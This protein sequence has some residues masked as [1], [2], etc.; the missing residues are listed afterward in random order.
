MAFQLQVAKRT[1]Y[2]PISLGTLVR[3]LAFSAALAVMLGFAATQN[4]QA[5]GVVGDGTPASC[6]D[7]AYANAMMGGG[8]VTFNCGPDP[9][10][11]PVSTKVILAGEVTT[12]DGNGR[13][14]LDGQ[15]LVQLFIVS[16]GGELNLR[17]LTLT[18]GAT[19]R[20]SV[21]NNAT[22]GTVFIYKSTIERNGK[23]A[24]GVVGP[25]RGGALY[26]QGIM[27]IEQSDVSYNFASDYGGAIWNQGTLTIR[28]AFI[29][30]NEVPGSNGDGGAIYNIGDMR[31]EDSTLGWNRTDDAGGAVATIDGEVEIT[32]STIRE[33]YADRGGG[34]YADNPGTV[35]IVNATIE[36]NN[37][38]TAGNVYNN[39]GM[40]TISIHN[41][42]IANGST[43]ADNGTPSL[44][45][46]GPGFTSLGYNIIGD[47]SCLNPGLS[48]DQR[49]TSPLL[50]SINDNGGFA[51]TVMPMPGSPAINQGDPTFCPARD[52]R[53][54][55]RPQAV[56]CDVGAVEV[57][58]I[59]GGDGTPA[60]LLPLV[61]GG[62]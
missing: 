58:L 3:I 34:L 30:N 10:V 59:E 33:N 14:T 60:V 31:I 2:R 54:F 24:G 57:M 15:K 38:D 47:N 61:N 29:H 27:D 26:N 52:Q 13:V 7:A 45:C 6:T 19:F 9:V 12:I 55:I 36:R 49:D 42:I 1:F 32:N 40:A 43:R 22:N 51:P 53:G 18:G 41:T 50:A 46:D 56:I 8:N 37:S 16:N 39:G 62:D 48:S 20:G 44:D 25:D 4:A 28:K 21:V 35:E 23:D 5:A 11:I 17:N